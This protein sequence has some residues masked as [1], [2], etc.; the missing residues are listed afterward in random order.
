MSMESKPKAANVHSNSMDNWNHKKLNTINLAKSYRRIGEIKKSIRTHRCGE[1]LEFQECPHG[2]YKKLVGANFCRLR[3]CPMCSWRRSLKIVHQLRMITHEANQRQKLRWLFLTLTVKNVSGFSLADEITRIF[4]SWQRLSQRKNFRQ[5]VI[6]WFRALEVTVNIQN[7]TYHPHLH[8]LLAVQPSYFSGTKY[9]SQ[10]KWV[11]LW[12]ESLRV[13]YIPVV[14]VRTIKPKRNKKRELE[15]L[16]DKEQAL[17]SAVLE[18][19]KYPIK[20]QNYILDNENDTDRIT[21]VLDQSLSFRRLVAYGGLLKLIWREI[22]TEENL[23]KSIGTDIHR[24][25]QCPTCGSDM[26]EHMY[27]WNIGVREYIEIS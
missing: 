24:N 7:W 25:C 11:D 13:D 4:Q 26:L 17:Q 27:N 20:D 5:S 21:K 9:I 1:Y 22:S 23:G 6:G 10:K 16:E 3:L 2:H 18:V 19:A 8:V 14:D 15:I 12:R